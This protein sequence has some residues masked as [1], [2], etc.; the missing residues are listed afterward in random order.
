MKMNVKML[1]VIVKIGPSGKAIKLK[2]LFLDGQALE[3]FGPVKSI[4]W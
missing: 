1:T 4:N 3:L 2:D